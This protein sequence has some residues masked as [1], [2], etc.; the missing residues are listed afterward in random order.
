MA[1]Y[2]FVLDAASNQR[3]QVQWQATVPA[4]I[5][6]NGRPLFSFANQ[7]EQ[8]VGREVQLPDGSQL[9]VRLTGEQPEVWRNGSPLTP[10]PVQE[11]EQAD[12]RRRLGGCLTTWLVLNLALIILLTALYLFAAQAVATNRA[13]AAYPSSVFL[14]Y[15]VIGLIGIAGLV[16]LFFWK[17]WGFYAVVAYVILNIIMDIVLHIVTLRS[18]TPLLGLL[19]LY[20][21]LQRNNVWQRLN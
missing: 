4:T 12:Q 14:I 9:F 7:Q 6:L 18:F 16:A 2:E 20:G 3:V 13:I 10:I 17:K 15:A 11:A 1:L 8:T 21:L 19:V 5:S